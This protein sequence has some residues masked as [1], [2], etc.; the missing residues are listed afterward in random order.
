MS[1]PAD[2][3]RSALHRMYDTTSTEGVPPFLRELYPQF[4]GF[5]D[6]L[7]TG[8]THRCHFDG[9]G[10]SYVPAEDP[11]TPLNYALEV[12]WTPPLA[13]T[14]STQTALYRLRD[15]VGALLYV[16]ISEDPLRRWPQ[17]AAEKAWW[18]EVAH[19]SLEWLPSRGEALL[20]EKKAI[21]AERP[22]HNIVHNQRTAA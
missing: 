9:P 3:E 17:H 22:I 7:G 2:A 5:R 18:P 1:A 8:T 4:I 12:R 10:Y 15:R 20:A 14:S 21:R 16:G 6:Y 11:D 19:F 13:E